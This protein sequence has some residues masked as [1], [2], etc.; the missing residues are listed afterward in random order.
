MTN[1][2]ILILE[3]GIVLLSGY[4]IFYAHQKGR[5]Q[6][7]KEDLKKLT[8][9]VENVKMKNSKEIESIKANLVLLTNKSKQIFSEEKDSII[10]FFAQ[11]NTWI[12][13]ALNINVEN[14]SISNIETIKER[15][16]K[17]Q[18]ASNKTNVAFAKVTL[19]INDVELVRLGQEA[20]NKI[21]DVHL[22]RGANLIKLHKCLIEQNE[23]Q[24]R[25]NNMNPGSIEEPNQ[26]L[27]D[28]SEAYDELREKFNEQ[29]KIV[30]GYKTHNPNVFNN[31]MEAVNAFKDSAQNYLR[32]G[33]PNN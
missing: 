16:I 29:G 10:V 1:T 14:L 24:D 19:I 18:D 20:I 8:E 2:I 5:N 7:D 15:L 11:L 6:A 27:F 22:F 32:K 33:S 21:N 13:E 23:I 28:Y 31:A 4:L 17:M 25:M 26:E 3:V 9:I 30:N 12:W